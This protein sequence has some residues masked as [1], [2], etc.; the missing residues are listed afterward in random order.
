MIDQKVTE[1]FNIEARLRRITNLKKFRLNFSRSELQDVMSSSR[2]N[3][4]VF[5]AILKEV[6]SL[7]LSQTSLTFDQ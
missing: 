7:I 1:M 6:K 5:P 4:P 3:W 2:F